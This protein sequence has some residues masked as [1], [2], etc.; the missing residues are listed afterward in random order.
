MLTSRALGAI[1]IAPYAVYAAFAA[2]RVYG[3]NGRR[4]PVPTIVFAFSMVPFATNIYNKAESNIIPSAPPFACT[5]VSNV[6][7]AVA[8]R[9]VIATRACTIFADTLVLLVTWRVTYSTKRS[10]EKANIRM[11]V[12]GLLFRDG[13]LFFAALTIL[14][15][16][17]IICFMTGTFSQFSVFLEVL[18]S[19]LISR[20]FLN[21][22]QACSPS[23]ANTLASADGSGSLRFTSSVLG[24]LDAP[25]SSTSG[26]DSELSVRNVSERH[27][28]DVSEEATDPEQHSHVAVRPQDAE[29]R[30]EAA[31]SPMVSDS[32]S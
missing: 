22:R 4:W 3:I 28:R 20:F 29:F 12:S 16:V 23:D 21:L 6:P 18:T 10:A 24:N 9:F 13:T 25:L 15:I 7:M 19:I 31:A 17:H 26:I 1:Q 30:Q 32:Q 5:V 14:N 27:R 8:D 11:S 2:L